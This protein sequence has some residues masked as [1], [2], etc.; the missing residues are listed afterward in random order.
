MA[1]R[2][3]EAE[4]GAEEADARLV[5]ALHRSLP[6]PLEIVEARQVPSSTLSTVQNVFDEEMNVPDLGV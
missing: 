1:C 2:D 3:V 4:R 5:E 6:N